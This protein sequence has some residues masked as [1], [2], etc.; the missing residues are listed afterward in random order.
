MHLKHY[1]LHTERTYCDRIKQFVKF[2]RMTE[3]QD[4][5]DNSEA[6]IEAFLSHLA[7][8][9]NVAA[10]TQN[11]GMNALMFLYKQ[12]LDKPLEKRI[13]ALRSGKNRRLHIPVVLSVP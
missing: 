3:R 8:E 1:S 10:S 2:H 13:D 9:R 7:T 4:L 12:V 11:Q 5:F 6:K